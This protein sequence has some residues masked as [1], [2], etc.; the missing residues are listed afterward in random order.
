MNP[1][2]MFTPPELREELPSAEEVE[3]NLLTAVSELCAKYHVPFSVSPT[4]EEI[5]IDTPDKSIELEFATKLAEI[6]EEYEVFSG[7]D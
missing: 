4:T 2:F 3:K 1:L 6:Y 5:F 7:V